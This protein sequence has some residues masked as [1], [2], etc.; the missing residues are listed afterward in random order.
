M[1]LTVQIT[2]TG[3]LLAEIKFSFRNKE[4]GEKFGILQ[5]S[6]IKKKFNGINFTE[7]IIDI[8]NCRWVDPLLEKPEPLTT[9]CQLKVTTI[10]V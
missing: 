5:E 1:A 10:L 2:I 9:L 3:K 7:A 4:W 6:F 8:S